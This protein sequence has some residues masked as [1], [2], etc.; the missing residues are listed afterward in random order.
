[1][2]AGIQLVFNGAT[3]SAL[4]LPK[5]FRPICFLQQFSAAREYRFDL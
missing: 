4:A 2:F 1:M 5:H 3:A